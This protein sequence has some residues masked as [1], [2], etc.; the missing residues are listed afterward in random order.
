M[1]GPNLGLPSFLPSSHEVS[2]FIS[3][4]I[5]ASMHHHSPKAIQKLLN[6]GP[7]KPFLI[8]GWFLEVQKKSLLF[9]VCGGGRWCVCMCMHERVWNVE[10]VEVRGP[11]SVVT[12]LVLLLCGFWGLNSGREAYAASVLPTEPCCWSSGLCY[13]NRKLSNTGKSYME[14]RVIEGC[15]RNWQHSHLQ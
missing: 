15:L 14:A 5:S 12:S 2:N 10:H 3:P 1:E 9:C 4:T 8:I 6:G 7:L 11:F 13:S